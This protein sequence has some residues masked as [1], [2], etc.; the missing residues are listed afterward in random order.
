MLITFKGRKTGR[1]YTTPVR[2][3]RTDDAIRAYTSCDSLW[4]RNLKDGAEVSL[5][6]AGEDR[7]YHAV[8]VWDDPPRV[9][10]ALLQ[11]FE[12]YPQDAAYHE[13]K[14]DRNKQPVE[15]DL[16]RA[17]REAIFVEARPLQ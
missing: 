15:E 10:E 8:A 12:A 11:Y 9:R 2:Y 16:E 7:R 3:V 6:I 14:L 13:V 17:S 4:W 1:E 5:R